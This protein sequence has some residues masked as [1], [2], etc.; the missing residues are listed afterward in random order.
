MRTA[1]KAW[2]YFLTLSLLVIITSCSTKTNHEKHIPSN[3]SMVAVLDVRKMTIK[4]FDMSLLLEENMLEQKQQD[5]NKKKTVP[6]EE[7]G[8]DFLDKSYIIGHVAD[9]EADNYIGFIM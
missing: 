2:I 3:A 9:N 8:I 6:I 4:A 5:K 7:S 1:M